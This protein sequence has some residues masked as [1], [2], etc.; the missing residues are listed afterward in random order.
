[1]LESWKHYI[2]YFKQSDLFYT[3]NYNKLYDK[4]KQVIKCPICNYPLS[5]SDNYGIYCTDNILHV[6]KGYKIR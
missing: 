4:D 5:Y 6:K 2:H 3:D 1:M